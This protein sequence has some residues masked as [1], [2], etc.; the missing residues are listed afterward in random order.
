MTAR[1]VSFNEEGGSFWLCNIGGSSRGRQKH[2]DKVHA[3]AG[4]WWHAGS[5]YP[6][7]RLQVLGYYTAVLV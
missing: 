1:G 4:D 3:Y 5:V 2:L 7:A 6:G